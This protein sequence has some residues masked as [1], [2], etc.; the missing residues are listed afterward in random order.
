MWKVLWDTCCYIQTGVSFFKPKMLACLL[1]ALFYTPLFCLEAFQERAGIVVSIEPLAMLVRPLLY[2]IES[3]DIGPLST[4]APLDSSIHDISVSL[5]TIHDLAQAR[6]VF[7]VGPE[8]ESSLSTTLPLC[9]EKLVTLSAF[10]DVRNFA[11]IPSQI[12]A[13]CCCAHACQENLE[14][15]DLHSPPNFRYSDWH[16]WYDPKAAACMVD[17]IA[18]VLCHYYPECKEKIQENHLSFLK[19]LNRVV[20]KGQKLF[21]RKNLRSVGVVH[22]A[23]KHLFIAL[24]LKQPHHFPELD[25]ILISPKELQET[26]QR[27]KNAHVDI[28]LVEW[29]IPST[30]AI[31]LR[32]YPV[33]VLSTD[34]LVKSDAF[35]AVPSGS[36]L[37]WFECLLSA[38]VEHLVLSA[39]DK[40][41]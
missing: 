4:I 34:G 31:I 20:E 1:A 2:Q 10:P 12:G 38:L 13:S 26:L 19:K 33:E 28:F 8:L 25:E 24:N 23:Y 17:K 32:F 21:A 11:L 7:W 36:Y 15:K 14:L 39:P 18:N 22:H 37:E 16:L 9:A 30:L 27:V 3:S 40:K 5:K 41:L 29:E 6:V 35:S